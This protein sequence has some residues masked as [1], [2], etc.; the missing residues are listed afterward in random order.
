MLRK[1]QDF[2]NYIEQLYAG[3]QSPGNIE[4][5]TISSGNFLLEQG[6]QPEYVYLIKTGI[7]KVFF[8]EENA[9]EYI[10]EFLSSGE[11]LGELEII[12][13][14]TCLCNVMAIGGLE[15]F[16]MRKHYFLELIDNDREFSKMIMA[17]FAERIINTSKKASFQKLYTL[18]D[19]LKEIIILQR[20]NDLE[21]SKADLSAYLGISVRSLNR[22]LKKLKETGC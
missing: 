20:E 7:C 11:I 10:L 12:R 19:A 14:M 1:N 5:L 9:R 8:E 18:E 2:L 16:R 21:I 13:E 4:L 22:S 6:E 15:V 17:S 3:Q